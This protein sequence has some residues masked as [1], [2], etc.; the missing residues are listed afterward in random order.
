[1]YCTCSENLVTLYLN[2]ES[3]GTLLGPRI[4]W[5]CTSVLGPRILWHST[6]S[7]NLVALYLVQE[8]CCYVPQ[9]YCKVGQQSTLSSSTSNEDKLYQQSLYSSCGRRVKDNLLTDMLILDPRKTGVRDT[10]LC[11][12]SSLS[13]M[14]DNQMLLWAYK[15][16]NSFL[17]HF[18]C[19]QGK[20][21]AI[22]EFQCNIIWIKFQ[23]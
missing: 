14:G 8:S 23:T 12:S 6:W 17:L 20:K 13:L 21:L 11:K 5:H 7:K 15:K 1:M 22:L 4:L 19:L 9:W 10:F 3:C 2:L 16:N 18:Y